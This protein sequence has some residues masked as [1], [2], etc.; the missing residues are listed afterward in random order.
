MSKV[1][2]YDSYGMSPTPEL[3]NRLGERFNEF[4]DMDFP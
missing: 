1:I 4:I 3:T 2:R